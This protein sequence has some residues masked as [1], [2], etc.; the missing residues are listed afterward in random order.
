MKVLKNIFIVL[1]VLVAI[2]LIVALFLPSTVSV[3][4]SIEV[5][6]PSNVV[7]SY[8]A[9][10]NN[11]DY[12]SPWKEIEPTAQT[13]VDGTPGT[14]GHKL[15]WKG[16]ETGEGS[17][18]ITELVLDKA[19]K[20]QLDFIEP[21]EAVAKNDWTFEST[22]SGTKVTWY[23]EGNADYPIGRYFGLM[24]DG[25]IGPDYEKGLGKLKANVEAIVDTAAEVVEGT[26]E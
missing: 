16:Q 12:W 3:Q 7:Y 18:T 26:E 6:K 21:W 25:M 22:A 11:F 20:T 15:S 5:N 4:R 2:F 9:D 19:V 23:Y 13:N 24:T 1:I 17:F 10:F 8:V 14:V